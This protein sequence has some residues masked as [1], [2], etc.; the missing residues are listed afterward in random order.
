MKI[1]ISYSRHHKGLGAMRVDK[2]S[3]EL[4]SI[5]KAKPEQVRAQPGRLP[6][7]P[8]SKVASGR[9]LAGNS[10]WPPRIPVRGLSGAGL[11]GQAAAVLTNQRRG[12]WEQCLGP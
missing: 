7:T 8:R 6:L 4:F 11:R 10:P 5:L 9:Q 1:L 2:M 3:Q 12:Y